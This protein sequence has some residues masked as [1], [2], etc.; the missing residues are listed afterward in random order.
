MNGE[1]LAPTGDR[2][3]VLLPSVRGHQRSVLV[4]LNEDLCCSGE[5]LPPAFLGHVLVLRW[6]HAGAGMEIRSC[7]LCAA[8]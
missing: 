8:G 1:G 7:L 6:F 4:R 2:D 5:Q 3:D